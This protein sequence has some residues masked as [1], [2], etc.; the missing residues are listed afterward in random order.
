MFRDSDQ[1]TPKGDPTGAKGSLLKKAEGTG[2]PCAGRLRTK[3][4]LGN[5]LILRWSRRV[6]MALHSFDGNGARTTVGTSARLS[7]VADI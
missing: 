1:P 4:E 6:Y 5:V 3:G 7:W 2:A